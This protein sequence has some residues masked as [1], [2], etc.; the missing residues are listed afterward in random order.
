MC[1]KDSD[2]VCFS[3]DRIP[4]QD[5]H[6]DSGW[7]LGVSCTSSIC[8]CQISALLVSGSAVSDCEAVG[9]NPSALSVVCACVLA[10]VGLGHIP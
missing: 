7:F 10:T 5:A 8:V 2:D 9:G 1:F 6:G 3:E 4:F